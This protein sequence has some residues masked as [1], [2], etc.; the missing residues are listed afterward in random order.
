[1]KALAATLILAIVTAAA[2]AAVG[3]SSGGPTE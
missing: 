2:T 1:M 3:E